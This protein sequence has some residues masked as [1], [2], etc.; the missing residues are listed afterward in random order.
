MLSTVLLCSCY[1]E[2]KVYK[3]KEMNTNSDIVID[4]WPLS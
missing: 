4:S 2:I 3:I 1:S